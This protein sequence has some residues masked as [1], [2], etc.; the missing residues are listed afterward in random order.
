M[1]QGTALTSGSF[2]VDRIA[3]PHDLSFRDLSFP[4][5]LHPKVSDRLRGSPHLYRRLGIVLQHLAAHGRTTVVKGCRDA[6]RGW[7]RSPLGGSGGTQYYL[8]WTL[9][10]S[11]VATELNLAPTA[12]I[13]RAVREH[14]DHSPLVAGSLDDYLELS[15]PEYLVDDESI[16]GS[17]WTDAQTDFVKSDRPVRLLLGR[18]GA[19]KTTALWRAVEARSGQRVLYLSW[20]S[21]LTRHAE[22][23]F[24]AFAP[25]DVEIIVR[26]FAT[27]VGEICGTDL[28]RKTLADSRAKF[29]AAIATRGRD[30]P[31]L[32]KYRYA[33]LHAELR[34]MLYGQAIPG[35]S[36][37]VDDGVLARLSDDEYYL[38]RSGIGGVG[39]KPA[40]AVLKVASA[41]SGEAMDA[42][43]PELVAANRAIKR[44][45]TG[46][47]PDGFDRFDRIV[48]DEI[49]DLTL[50]ETAVVVEF[51]QAIARNNARSPW[52][53][54]AGDSGQTVRPTGFEWGP[55]SDLVASRLGAPVKFHLEE[56]LRCPYRIAEVVDRVADRYSE[57]DKSFRPTKQRRQHS[58]QHVDAHL[59]YVEVASQAEGASL[60]DSLDYADNVVLISP[61]SDPLPWIPEES[62][63]CVLTPE[64][65]K[66]LEYQSVCVLDPGPVLAGLFRRDEDFVDYEIDQLEHRTAIDHLRVTISRA[67]ETLAFIDVAPSSAQRHHSMRTLG[68]AMP[69]S[70][71]D[72]VEH[73]THYDVSPEERVLVRTNDA[74][75]LIES[76]PA[77]AWQRVFQAFRLL[78]E[79]DLPN[80]V[81]DPD[82]RRETRTVLFATA[83]R[84]MI[85]G[86]PNESFTARVEVYETALGIASE[87]RAT[88]PAERDGLIAL[89]EWT[90]HSKSLFALLDSALILS[91]ADE[92][93]DWLGPALLSV[94]QSLRDGLEAYSG[95]REGAERF[96]TPAVEGWLR[97]TG[98]EG[99]V[100]IKAR[101]LRRTAFDTLVEAAEEESQF[102]RKPLLEIAE[103][104]L[105]K[106]APDLLRLGRLR[107]AQD[108]PEDAVD[109]YADVGATENVLRVWRQRGSWERAIEFARGDVRADL[110]WLAEF[111]K[112]IADRPERQDERLYPGERDRLDDLLRTVS[113]G[114]VRKRIAK[115]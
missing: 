104:L 2:E 70:A 28:V 37:C 85:G 8:W 95:K 82:I 19:G 97:L 27:F 80:G 47:L 68:D 71:E 10:G 87:S 100:A 66:G 12:I 11:K 36:D 102:N 32:W 99:D 25:A 40:S 89:W 34:A 33:A 62:R 52:L 29:V 115:G 67:T 106:I 9:Q 112:L 48:V 83:A 77:R 63:D 22:E 21:A 45:R 1:A 94:A 50:L 4:I 24:R 38:R 7:R 109:A 88:V 96:D 92:S 26:D 113:E 56:H 17:P 86:L 3:S 30:S 78:G 108:R 65:A 6:N 84:L 98:Y 5:W 110:E 59:I 41:L 53:L 49:Q 103:S 72:L 58:G 14:D 15:S 44:L 57:I 107:E 54:M 73:F 91:N 43:F 31:R 74:R 79:P 105:G 60:V 39:P 111:E 42:V 20:S 93:G 35:D 61:H 51:C 69:F 75:A 55:I 90:T 114:R 16:A 13:V 76:A 101:G 46:L 64:Q 18:P 81:S 23:R